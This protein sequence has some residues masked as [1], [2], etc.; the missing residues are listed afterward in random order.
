MGECKTKAIQTNLGTFRHNQTYRGIIQAYLEP[1]HTL[2]YLKLWYVQNADI[3]R[4]LAYSQLLYIQNPAVFRMVTYSKSEAYTEP[5]HTST[6]KVTN[7][8]YFRKV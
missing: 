5:C 8:N 6:M 4:T 1:C 7:Y 2:T 3:F